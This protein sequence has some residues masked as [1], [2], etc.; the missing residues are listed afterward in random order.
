MNLL[1]N[2]VSA[3]ILPLLKILRV[4]SITFRIWAKRVWLLEQEIGE[5]YAVQGTTFLAHFVC[6][7][8]LE[9]RELAL[10]LAESLSLVD[11]E[12]LVI[13]LLNQDKPNNI[14]QTFLAFFN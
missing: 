7:N 12:H 13:F 1:N 3:Y 9:A 10:F 4:D 6:I 14:P 5:E 8:P 11:K 2:K